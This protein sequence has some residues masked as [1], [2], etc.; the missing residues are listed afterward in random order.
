[1]E[2]YYARIIGVDEDNYRKKLNKYFFIGNADELQTSFDV[3]AAILGK[4]TIELPV[5]NITGRQRETQAEFLSPQQISRFKQ[6]NKLDYEIFNYIR[7][8]FDLL[9]SRYPVTRH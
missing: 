2:N 4:A 7:D 6:A 8:R 1:M 3:L 9:K 5:I